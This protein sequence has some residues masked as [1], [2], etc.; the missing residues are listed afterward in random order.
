MSSTVDQV[1]ARLSIADVISPYVRLT[2]AGANFKARCPF[3]HEKTP[4]FMVSVDR[5][6]YHCFGCSVGG[7]IF[8]FVQEIEGV[9]FKGAL[10]ILAEKAGV[11][12][13]YEKRGERDPTDRLYAALEEATRF[14]EK[15][16]CAPST[17]DSMAQSLP[18]TPTEPHVLSAHPAYAYLKKR[19][20]TDETIRS[21]RLGFVSDEWRT[22]T[23][24]LRAKKYSDK[25]IEA[26][27]LAKRTEK[28]LYDR[29]RSRIMFPLFDPAGRVVG[30]SG[31][32]FSEVGKVPDDVAK[33]I[34]S[35]ETQLY[36]KS[37][38]LYGYDRAKQSIRK[39]NFSIVVEGQMDLLMV[40]QAGWTNAIAVSGTAFTKEHIEFLMRHSE[41][42]VLAL[43]AD[44]AG[45]KAAQRFATASL[46]AGMDVKVA[47]LPKGSDPADYILAEGKDAWK[48]RIREARH[49][50]EFLLAALKEHNASER[51]YIKAVR[52]TV[53]PFIAM[54]KSAMDRDH[55]ICMVADVLKVSEDSVRAE[56]KDGKW[57]IYEPVDEVGEAETPPVPTLTPRMRRIF[58][59]V[60]SQN[61]AKKAL[62]SKRE[63]TELLKKHVGA[64]A[65]KELAGLSDKEQETLR[66]EADRALAHLPD[67][68]ERDE[69]MALFLLVERD[70][71][72][73]KR[74]EAHRHLAETE[75]TGDNAAQKKA[76][77][78]YT[79][80]TNQ[81]AKLKKTR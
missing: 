60:L 54:I 25:E 36:N 80:L 33:Y 48:A 76:F 59:I 10:K 15:N 18:Q 81:I 67:M 78:L 27:G 23:A 12:L 46:A 2:R 39:L 68:K 29:F 51:A 47:Q 71:F 74:K 75:A 38:L 11:P 37:R 35:P 55:F 8:T 5:G 66:F 42:M 28:G 13:V 3:H 49:V 64:D 31:R 62:F 19:G 44:D 34:N 16:L 70:M 30:F 24:H 77:E 26:A 50:V 72:E 20:L 41:N 22:L 43:D 57:S 4:S 58:G 40:H 45:L 73:E 1:K 21:F 53:L 79:H 32:I 7:D 9:D 17:R 65:V 6:T 14:F 69:I 63:L 61:K 52:S 56:L